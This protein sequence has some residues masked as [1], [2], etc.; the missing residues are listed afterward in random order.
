[1]KTYKD[2]IGCVAPFSSL[3]VR[4]DG[5]S[6]PCCKFNYSAINKVDQTKDQEWNFNYINQK[7]RDEFLQK[8][9]DIANYKDCKMCSI[10]PKTGQHLMHNTNAKEEIDY[11]A[12][13]T[14]TNL[15]LKFS[16][17]CNLA[18][19]ICESGC[20][21]LIHT[22][23]NLLFNA[24]LR[25]E[26]P[27]N[28]NIKLDNNSVLM[29]SFKE[30]IHNLNT[31]YFSGGEPLLQ[32]EVWEFLTLANDQGHSKNI[33]LQFNTNGTV[34]LNQE[35]YNILKS[36]KSIDISVSMDGIGKHAEYIRTNTSWPRWVENI[37]NYKAEFSNYPNLRLGIVLTVSV[38]NVHIVDK[39]LDFF[40]NEIDLNVDLNFVHW[41]PHL[42]VL[43]LSRKLKDSLIEYYT[44]LAKNYKPVDKYYIIFTELSEFLKNENNI[45]SSEIVKFIDLKDNLVLENS[46]YKN[47]R[48]FREVDPEWYNILKG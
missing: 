18:C 44:G 1:M 25:P 24:G 2:K 26:V 30:N 13:P 46:L 37:K 40:K 23:D 32:D 14:L 48:P 8:G 43:N 22:E 33:D 28:P 15:H 12:N 7:V 29:Q 39:V 41:P 4:S 9:N 45:I 36:F 16:N 42:C 6:F 34:K 19:R 5:K 11:I 3:F 20:S 10:N 38:F 21:S 47:Y 31:L 27:S 35:R 17:Q